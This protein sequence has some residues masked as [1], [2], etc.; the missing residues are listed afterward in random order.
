MK[1]RRLHRNSVPGSQC[2]IFEHQHLVVILSAGESEID[3][4]RL[5]VGSLYM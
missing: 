2:A 5:N 1:S 3:K 4:Q